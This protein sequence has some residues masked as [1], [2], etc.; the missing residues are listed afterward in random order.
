M[1]PTDEALVQACR[2]NDADA[3]EL[4]INRYQRLIY[5]IPR[6]A[7][8]DD[9]LAGEVFQRVFIRL[10]QKLDS[11]E[12]PDRLSAWLSTV[13]RRET[14]RVIQQ[15]KRHPVALSNADDIAAIAASDAL[16]DDMIA[17]IEQQHTIRRALESL[18]ERCA[19]LLALLY[20]RPAPP[21]Y[22][23]I[24][25]TLGVTI[26]S[27]GPTRARCLEKLKKRLD[28]IGFE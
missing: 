20:Y 6:R 24:A 28:A 8:L 4:L 10:V 2:R 13:A 3:W 16:P 26:G 27:V 22:S 5:T 14:W 15:E 1:E 23:E 9:D 12:Q 17:Q 18:D 25:T 7:G 19:R 11:I 21:A